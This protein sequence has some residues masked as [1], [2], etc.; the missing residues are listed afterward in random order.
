MKLLSKINWLLLILLVAAIYF[1]SKIFSFFHEMEIL[2]ASLSKGQYSQ[3]EL[4]RMKSKIQRQQIELESYKNFIR[5]SKLNY[6][7]GYKLV[8]L[9]IVAISN[10]TF[11]NT[12]VLKNFP[13]TNIVVGTAVLIGGY[14][15]GRVFKIKNGYTYVVLLNDINSQVIAVTKNI[16]KEGKIAEMVLHGDGENLNIVAEKESW[17]KVVKGS[18]VYTKGEF[19]PANLLIGVVDVRANGS[20]FVRMPGKEIRLFKFASV[21]TPKASNTNLKKN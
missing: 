14:I 15:I 13:D 18:K 12:V 6:T 1:S 2:F 17:L 9:P 8:T 20:K 19:F 16:D 3:S 10:N 7:A 5:Q 11:F 4:V 21:F